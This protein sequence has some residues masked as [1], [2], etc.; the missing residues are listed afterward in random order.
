[1]IAG[2]DRHVFKSFECANQ[3]LAPVCEHWGRRIIGHGAEADGDEADGDD[4]C[5]AHCARR[6]GVEEIVD[7]A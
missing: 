1:M 5:C 6:E 2:G 4:Y 3:A 7:H